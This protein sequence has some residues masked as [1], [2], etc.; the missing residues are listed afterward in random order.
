MVQ[1]K[2]VQREEETEVSNLRKAL[3]HYRAQ[4]SHLN[5]LNDQLVNANRMIRQDLED[6]N[7]NYVELVRVTV[8]VV[9]R[10]KTAMEENAELLKQNQTL[11]DRLPAVEEE[12]A[13][14]RKRSQALD[15]LTILAEATW[16]L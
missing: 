10:R 5:H 9:K 15:G 8:E 14:L 16:N 2:K 4:N 13:R 6:I 3:H 12:L 11:Q 1:I 7:A